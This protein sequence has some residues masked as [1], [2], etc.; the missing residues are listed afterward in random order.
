MP[1]PLFFCFF[2]GF[3]FSRFIFRSI[4]V[5][6]GENLCSIANLCDESTRPI[7]DPGTAHALVRNSMEDT[8]I[9]TI[10]TY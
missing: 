4:M 8:Y 7:P 5:V 1:S 2:G 3:F 6:C 9:C 10:H